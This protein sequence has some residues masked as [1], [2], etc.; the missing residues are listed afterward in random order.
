LDRT[1]FDVDVHAIPAHKRD[2]A[3]SHFDVRFLLTSTEGAPEH[4]TRAEDPDRPMRWVSLDAAH[5]MGVDP[6]LARALGKARR[7][8]ALVPPPQRGGGAPPRGAGGPGARTRAQRR[9]W[10][11]PRSR[12]C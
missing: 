11:R 5:A 1:I 12:G 4:A 10:A 9:G 7:V 2:P 8:L 3:H 6:S